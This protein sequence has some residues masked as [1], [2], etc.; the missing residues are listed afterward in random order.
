[1]ELEIVTLAARPD[2]IEVSRAATVFPAQP[3][4]VSTSLAASVSWRVESSK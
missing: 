2:L 4:D 1:M 3:I